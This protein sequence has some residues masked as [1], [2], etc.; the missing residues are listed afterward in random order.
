MPAGD[1]PLGTTTPELARV[2]L[3][4]AFMAKRGYLYILASRKYGTLYIGVTSNL[5]ARIWAHRQGTNEGFTKRYRVTRLV[6]AE[7]Y[8]DIRDAIAREKQLKKWRRPWKI[9]LIE[10]LNPNWSDLFEE[11]YF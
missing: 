5:S 6:Y 11:I 9:A 1:N 4:N 2:T 3:Q 8:D 10:G 7:T